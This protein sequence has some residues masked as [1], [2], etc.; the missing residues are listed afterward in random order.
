MSLTLDSLRR[1]ANGET[2]P[3]TEQELASM[4]TT[5]ARVRNIASK[6]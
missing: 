3:T 5:D 2:L 4:Q 1:K 6:M